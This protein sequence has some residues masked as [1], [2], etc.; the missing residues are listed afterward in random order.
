MSNLGDG[1]P[2]AKKS[3]IL[4]KGRMVEMRF[5]LSPGLR[6]TAEHIVC[7]DTAMKRSGGEG[8]NPHDLAHSGVGKNEKT[9]AVMR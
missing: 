8:A 1:R 4:E 3:F 5:N 6:V 9:V 2:A 7:D